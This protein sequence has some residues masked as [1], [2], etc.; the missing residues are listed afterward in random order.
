M[1]RILLIFLAL[2]LGGSVQAG[3]PKKHFVL[4]AMLTADTPVLLSDGAR[5]MMDK[6]DTFPVV[7]YKDDYTK[8]VLQL[9]G[10]TFITGAE[11]V[12]V[13][14]EK[15]VTEEQLA[16]YKVNVQHYIDAQSKKWKDEK[17]K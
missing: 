8:L 15:D 6:G 7:M 14:E 16:T 3:P 13:I 1:N 10:T 4:Y 9:A 5:W 2:I 12:K 11:S 17:A